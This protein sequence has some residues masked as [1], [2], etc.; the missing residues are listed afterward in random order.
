MKSET[1]ITRFGESDR[2]RTFADLLDAVEG[3]PRHQ[4]AVIMSRIMREVTVGRISAAEASD[5]MKAS[6]N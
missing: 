6:K 2:K 4:K 3:V 5:I 1:L